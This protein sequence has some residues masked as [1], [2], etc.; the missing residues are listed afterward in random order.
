M[1]WRVGGRAT[2]GLQSVTVYLHI[3]LYLDVPENKRENRAYEIPAVTYNKLTVYYVEFCRIL[4]CVCVYGYS[5]LC[6][7]TEHRVLIY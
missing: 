3:G 1:K 2:D 4:T 6:R 5:I 7:E